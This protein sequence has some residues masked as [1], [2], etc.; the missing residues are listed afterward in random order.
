MRRT[1]SFAEKLKAELLHLPIQDER[2]C[3]SE[4]LGFIKSRG[5]L[6]VTAKSRY[7]V[8]AT[9][10]ISSLKRLFTLAKAL[11][12]SPVRTHLI[13]EHKLEHKRGGELIFEMSKLEGFLKESGIFIGSS[14][15]PS[16][17]KADAVYLGAFVR[18]L[19]LASGSVVDPSKGYH[20][21]ILLDGNDDFPKNVK[22]AVAEEFNIRL[23]LISVRSRTKLYVK[24]SEDLIELLSAMGAT[25][26]VSALS[27]TVEIRK[28][29]G[30][31]SRM[32]NFLTANADKSATAMV[33][34]VNA[35]MIVDRH[36]GLS[37]LP[38][39]LEAIAKLRLDNEAL[40]L[41]EL[42]EILEP[43]VSKSVVHNRLKKIERM[44]EK[45]GGSDE[46]SLLQQPDNEGP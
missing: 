33:R 25:H 16:A 15:L 26:F 4:F 13:H 40:S 18:G 20:L 19:F 46:V 10:S 3:K 9:N 5:A 23:G 29:R 22:R 41:R 14:V 36:I 39:E 35:I 34:Q 45:L 7:L 31:V 8:A 44:A 32:L 42:G 1:T 2:E 24:S 21:E 37:S 30:N 27:R 43:P 38:D 17:V 28:V 6:R 12:F 11:G